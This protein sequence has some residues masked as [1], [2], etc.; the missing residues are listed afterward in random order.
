[1][2]WDFWNLVSTV[3]AA[4]VAFSMLVFLW[5]FFVSVRKTELD[6]GPDPWDARTLEWSISSP[7]PHYNFAQI[8][9]VH[10]RDAFWDQKYA[11]GPDGIPTPIPS[12]GASNVE[13]HV[14]IQMPGLSYFPIITALG[15][16]VTFSGLLVHLAV[17]AV[18]VL[19]TFFG[20]YGWAF[21]PAEEAEEG[22]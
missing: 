10:G 5:N 22:H 16:A 17:V 19:V 1:M 12:G 2:G 11:E 13:E 7:P 21:E 4:V 20:A 18:G 8:P 3:G 6:A 15:L 14:N 9:T